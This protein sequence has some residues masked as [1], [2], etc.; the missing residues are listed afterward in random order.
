[1]PCAAP[2]YKLLL[3]QPRQVLTCCEAKLQCEISCC[4]ATWSQ[5]HAVLWRAVQP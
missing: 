3:F 2:I 4:G 5:M 1:M